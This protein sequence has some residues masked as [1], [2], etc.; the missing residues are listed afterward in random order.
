MTFLRGK[1]IEDYSDEELLKLQTQL[2]FN[3]EKPVWWNKKERDG[4]RQFELRIVNKEL[5]WRNGIKTL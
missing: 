4:K 1:Q 3:F 5:E 2:A